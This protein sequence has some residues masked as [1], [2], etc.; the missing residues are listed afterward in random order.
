MAPETAGGAAGGAKVGVVAERAW[1]PRTV[2]EIAAKTDRFEFPCPQCGGQ[3]EVLH[4]EVACGI[5]RHGSLR[6]NPNERLPP[7]ASRAQCEALLL[8]WSGC[9]KPF[10]FDGHVATLCD[11][12]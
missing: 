5:F 12:I 10:R 11:Y 9:G 6:T 4:R 8:P 7:H 1:V 2:T 3:V